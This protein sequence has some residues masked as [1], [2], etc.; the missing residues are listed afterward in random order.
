MAEQ[1]GKLAFEGFLLD[2]ANAL[3]W[4]GAERI[5][6]PPKPFGV[7]CCLAQR[8]GALV[9]KDELLD[10]VWRNLHVTESSLS[11][12]INAVRL[13]LG[14]DPRSPRFIETV[15]RRGYR[16]VAPVTV[17]AT[18]SPEAPPGMM[19]A[20]TARLAPRRQRWCA[21]RETTLSALE[22]LFERAAADRRQPRLRHR[23][24]RHRQ[25]DIDRNAGRADGRAAGR[26]IERQL[27]AAFR[28]RRGLFA[29]QRSLGRRLSRA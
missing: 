22:D 19:A 9:T 21:G 15:T 7:L 16:F 23:R 13:A 2:P 18:A 5:A 4:R 17:A 24:E 11:V 26:H 6:L 20:S 1:A 3:L 28:H 14:D 25:N 27:R 10:A 12:S 8:A 29:A